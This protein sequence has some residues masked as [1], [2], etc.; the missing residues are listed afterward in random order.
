MPVV[1][2]SVVLNMS[3]EV[4]QN[5]VLGDLASLPRGWIRACCGFGRLDF[6]WRR[7]WSPPC[8]AILPTVRNPTAMVSM[9]AVLGWLADRLTLPMLLPSGDPAAS[10]LRGA[11]LGSSS[12]AFH[13][14][15]GAIPSRPERSLWV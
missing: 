1:E 15:T 9:F 13:D 7:V 5:G 8:V 10:H 12:L 6:Q 2:N 14:Q 4:G 11:S 3:D